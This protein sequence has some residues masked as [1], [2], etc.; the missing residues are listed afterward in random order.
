MEPESETLI[1]IQKIRPV[2]N[3]VEFVTVVDGN[4]NSVST[5]SEKSLVIPELNSVTEPTIL[6]S[7]E[8]RRV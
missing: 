8:K 5:F 4:L 1:E 2:R 6:V 3:T 7:K